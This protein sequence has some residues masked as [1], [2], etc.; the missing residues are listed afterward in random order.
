MATAR[1]TKKAEAPAVEEIDLDAEEFDLE[2]DEAV[3]AAP[4]PK[5]KKA[6]A[7]K[8]AAE[9]PAKEKSAPIEFGS[10]W[11]ATHVNE[12]A[13]TAYDAYNL[14][15]LLRKLTKDGVLTRAESEGRARYS[16]TGPEDPQVQQIVEAVKSGAADQAKQERLDKLKAD[17]AS[18]PKATKAKATKAKAVEVEPDVDEEDDFETEDI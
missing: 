1:R 12:Q 9:K 3:E 11:L 18:K 7:A 10:A 4:A 2:E 8:V 14:R 5:A 6:K 15:I 16:F 17:R 13:G